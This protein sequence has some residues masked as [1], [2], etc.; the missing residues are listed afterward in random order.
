MTNEE[1]LEKVKEKTGITSDYKLAQVL[2]IPRERISDYR[3]GKRDP[4]VYACTK[5]AIAIGVPPIEIIAEVEARS[6]PTEN[7]RTF[8]RDFRLHAGKAAVIALALSFIP[9]W[10]TDVNAST[11]NEA[12]IMRSTGYPPFVILIVERHSYPSINYTRCK[13][14]MSGIAELAFCRG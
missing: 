1:L 3:K 13:N 14:F 11:L 5:I 9:T 4:D 2:D 10:S 12:S 6:A 8:W 7:K